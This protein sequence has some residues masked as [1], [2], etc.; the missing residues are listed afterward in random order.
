MS[1]KAFACF[2]CR[3]S[4][5]RDQDV[6]TIVCP[7]CKG[8]MYRMGWSFHAPKKRDSEQWKKVQLLFAE[9]FRFFGSGWGKGVPLPDKYKDVK[10]FIEENPEHGLRTKKRSPELILK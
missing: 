7:T 3:V 10:R 9:G 8:T 4:M 5:K 1:S 6:S 2:D